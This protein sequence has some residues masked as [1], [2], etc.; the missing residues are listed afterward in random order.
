MPPYDEGMGVEGKREK[1]WNGDPED[2]RERK[3][4]VPPRRGRKGKL[5]LQPGNRRFEEKKGK[6]KMTKV[7][8]TQGKKKSDLWVGKKKR[9]RGVCSSKPLGEK[10]L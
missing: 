7:R 4:K 3:G 6:K 5:P 2:R 9:G 10:I 1:N 8:Y